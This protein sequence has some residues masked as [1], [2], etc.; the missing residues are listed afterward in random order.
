MIKSKKEWINS[1]T[2][3]DA[4]KI[5]VIVATFSQPIMLLLSFI[6][7]AIF[8]N[9]LGNTY[10]GLN[11]LYTNL[12]SVLS[13]AELGIGS[14]I[15]AAMYI[16]VS[17]KQYD[18][19]NE[20]LHF[21][22][23]IY[24][25][26]GLVVLVLGF[27]LSFFLGYFIKGKL[28][29]FAQFGFILFVFNSALSYWMVTSQTL[30]ASDQ[31]NFVNVGLK[32]IFAT[33]F[34]GLQ[35]FVLIQWHNFILY[36][37]VQI[38]NTFTLNLVITLLVRKH[39]PFTRNKTSYVIPKNIGDTL[40]KNVFGMMSAKFGGIILSGSD[41]IILSTF[42]GLALVGQY[43]NYMIII[44]GIISLMNAIQSG[45]TASI[46]N[47]RASNSIK[48]QTD[49][50]FQL[51]AGSSLLTVSLVLGMS[52]FFDSLIQIWLGPSY[53]FDSTTTI[54]LIIT[55]YTNQI[56]QI[57]ISYITAYG[58]FWPLRYKSLIEAGVNLLLSLILVVKYKFG[59]NGV[60]IGT[61]VANVGINFIWEGYIV[62][63]LALKNNLKIYLL[64]L[65]KVTV[66]TCL[67][68][69]IGTMVKQDIEIN[70]TW[71]KLLVLIGIYVTM[72]FVIVLLFLCVIPQSR[73][74][75]KRALRK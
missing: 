59:V 44:A 64:T 6:T 72:L 7:R 17:N 47:L 19:I 65:I 51:F 38:I 4:A 32:F 23:R 14:A 24:R 57:S 52:L 54:L 15:T 41:N 39:Y 3:S 73:Q 58:L 66:I 30:L 67:A 18:L 28:P 8:I 56:R 33:L 26:I 60:L 70:Q 75:L 5:N 45:L 25:L 9:T 31:K 62:Q 10:N 27:V 53:I 40:K 16:P 36:L 20:L 46:G 35:I 43:S 37:I 34:Q 1:T 42:I 11:G 68:V 49:I 55:F 29:D 69:F 21:F 50:F 12:L 63:R 13:F 2:R 48:R 71:I 74:L 22:E 61:I